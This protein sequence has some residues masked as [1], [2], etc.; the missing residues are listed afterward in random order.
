MEGNELGEFILEKLAPVSNIVERSSERR[1]ATSF[2]EVIH[3][4][5]DDE[6]TIDG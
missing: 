3:E 6:E 5:S 1:N 2:P 4:V